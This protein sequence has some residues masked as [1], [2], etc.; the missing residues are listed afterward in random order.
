MSKVGR[1]RPCPCGSKR[2]YKHC[3]LLQHDGMRI[4]EKMETPHD[5]NK[6]II[7]RMIDGT[8]ER[9]MKEIIE[10]KTNVRVIN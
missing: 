7:K 8:H 9:N 6:Q 10:R 5:L 3:C 1:N 2:K 4:K